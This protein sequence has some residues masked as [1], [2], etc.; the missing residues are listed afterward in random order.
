MKKNELNLLKGLS[1]KELV[2]KAN[3]LRKEISSLIIDKNMKK[4]KDTKSVFKKRKDLARVLTVIRQKQLLEELESK[5]QEPQ[6]ESQEKQVSKEEKVSK[7]R[8]G[9]NS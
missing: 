6:T 1:I 9:V 5:S 3:D 2:K 4:L 7:A 8:K